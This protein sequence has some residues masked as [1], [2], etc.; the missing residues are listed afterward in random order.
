VVFQPIAG[1][2]PAGKY[3]IFADGFAGAVKEPGQAVHRPAGL[4][5]G[6]DGALYIAEDVHGRIW[7]VTYR[8]ETAATRGGC[9]VAHVDEPPSGYYRSMHY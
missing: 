1:G 4:A 7:R 9:G 5:V 3:E 2:K 6:P 8:G